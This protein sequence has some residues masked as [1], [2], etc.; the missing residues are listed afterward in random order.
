MSAPAPARGRLRPRPPGHIAAV[1]LA[2]CLCGARAGAAAT[3]GVTNGVYSLDRCIELG[4]RQ[5]AAAINAGR[6]L[7]IA[8]AGIRQARALVLPNLSANAAYTR[9]DE[10]TEVD[11]GGTLYEFGSLDNYSVDAKVSQLLYS[12]GKVRAALKAGDLA[13]RRAEWTQQRVASELVRNIRTQF[14]GILLAVQTVTVQREALEQFQ[15]LQ[16]QVERKYATGAAAEFDV[17]TAKVKVANQRPRVIEAANSLAVAI[18]A[19]QRLVGLSGAFTADGRLEFRPWDARLDDLKRQARLQRPALHEMRLLVALRE[20]DAEAARATGL[21]ELRAN[22]AYSGAN[23]YGITAGD[24]LDWHW[25]ATVTAA[26]DIW[27]GGLT[28]ATVLEKRL[29]VDKARTDLDD[30]ES[31]VDLEVTEAF[32]SMTHARQAYESGTGDVELAQKAFDIAASK[33]KAGLATYL[34]FTDANVALSNAKLIRYRAIY[35]HMNAVAR[36]EYAC[37]MDAAP[38][39]A[40]QGAR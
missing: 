26:W 32:L 1:C 12:G 3:P 15:A 8:A 20:Q 27:D 33:H 16:A 30:A 4:L 18:A 7:E 40:A 23:T 29:E 5:S 21:P 17:I 10:V 11:F 19:F 22:A 13:R 35:E 31:G 28:Q 34:D 38:A 36:L 37:G 9:N 6:D 25:S 24:E 14:H 39:G 2:A